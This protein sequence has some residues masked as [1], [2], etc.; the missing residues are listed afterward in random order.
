MPGAERRRAGARDCASA[1]IHGG[2]LADSALADSALADSLG[3]AHAYADGVADTHAVAPSRI[4]HVHVGRC[5]VFYNPI[6]AKT[7]LTGANPTAIAAAS[8]TDP[9]SRAHATV[10]VRLVATFAEIGVGH[11]SVG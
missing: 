3:V 11:E 10:A 6:R 1:G 5:D 2:L 7:R 9:S 8:A 4:P